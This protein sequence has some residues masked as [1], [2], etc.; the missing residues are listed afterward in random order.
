[1]PAP[2][3]AEGHLPQSAPAA[4]PQPAA[5]VAGRTPGRRRAAAPAD[6]PLGGD[7]SND[8]HEARESAAG[9]LAPPHRSDHGDQH[10]LFFPRRGH[11]CDCAVGRSL[12]YP[13]PLN[14]GLLVYLVYL[15]HLVYIPDSSDKTKDL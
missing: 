5:D 9:D 2:P 3:A 11:G 1:P 15:V 14:C 7:A 8:A 10:F 4:R 6:V 12:P 13:G